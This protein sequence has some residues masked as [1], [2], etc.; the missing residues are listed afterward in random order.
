MYHSKEL[1]KIAFDPV[2]WD[3]LENTDNDLVMKQLLADGSEYFET[4]IGFAGFVD[5]FKSMEASGNTPL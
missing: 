2:L 3:K 5:A 1:N 4:H